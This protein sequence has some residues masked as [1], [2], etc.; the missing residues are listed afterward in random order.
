[1]ARFLATVLRTTKGPLAALLGGVALFA[2]SDGPSAVDSPVDPP[3]TSTGSFELELPETVYA[4]EAFTLTVTAVGADGSRPDAKFG[5]AVALSASSGSLTPS[6]VTL[7]GG[8]GVAAVTLTGVAG[9]VSLEARVGNAIGTRALTAIGNAPVASIEV[10]PSTLLLTG[11]GQTRALSVRVLDADGLPT[12]ADVSWSTSNAGAVSVDADGVATAVAA[13]GSAQIVAQ[14]DGVSSLPALALVATPAPGAVLVDDSLVVGDVTAVDPTAEYGL[15]WRYQV[16]LRGLN[17]QP[18]AV[19]VGTGEQRIGGRVVSATPAGDEVVVVLEL[20]PLPEL[21]AAVQIDQTIPLIEGPDEAA[22][23]PPGASTWPDAGPLGPQRVEF[24]LGRFKCDASG[25]VPD[26]DLPN[27]T[28]NITPSLSL[29][30]GYTIPGGGLQSLAAVGSIGADAGYKPVFKAA[31]EGAVTCSTKLRTL[32]LPIGGW[33]SWFFGAQVP[34]GIGVKLDGK[35]EIAEIGFDVKADATATVELGLDCPPGGSCAGLN[36]F[37]VTRTGSFE[38]VAPDPTDQFKLTL[39]GHGYLWANLTLGSP[40]SESLQFEALAAKAGLKQ[41]VDLATAHKQA[42]DTDYASGFRLAFLANVGPGKDVDKAIKKLGDLLGT[43][44]KPDLTLL[45]VDEDLAESPKGTFTITPASVAPGDDEA[46]GELATFKVELD[47]V[48]YLGLES[49]DRVEIFWKRDDDDGGFTLE[50]GRPGCT[51]ISASAGQTLFECQTDFLAEHE[52]EQTFHAFVHAKL[53]GVPLPIPLEVAKDGS[54]V[55]QVG[56]LECGAAPAWAVPSVWNESW[57]SDLGD[58]G[59][60]K[61]DVIRLD[62]NDISVVASTQAPEGLGWSPHVNPKL[63]TEDYI[64]VLPTD[65]WPEDGII[66]VRVRQVG[67]TEALLTKGDSEIRIGSDYVEL[68]ASLPFRDCQPLIPCTYLTVA[69]NANGLADAGQLV[70]DEHDEVLVW[71][72]ARS[73]DPEK[74]WYRINSYVDGSLRTRGYRRTATGKVEYRVEVLGAEDS[75][76]SPVEVTIC[77]ASGT[78]Y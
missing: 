26:L 58:L 11:S 71:R 21:M 63:G 1:M 77:S 70:V 50:P 60:G 73:D 59:T 51:D 46:L 38:F 4:G 33:F 34:L 36:T 18:G 19:L 54:A 8:V 41:S 75:S 24:T 72:Y 74:A 35:L 5:G 57:I 65:G 3:V 55:L 31:F 62:Y 47:P 52:G 12:R 53:F 27:P 42:E 2:C 76:G 14:A 37:E 49:V 43:E 15:G 9:P 56:D 25:S 78:Q 48:T 40:L 29:R 64:R 32:I 45:N 17:V 7:T 23:G 69:V 20:I 22:G 30:V 10:T 13:L 61:V 28:F 66:N 6:S 16:R 68:R 39:G 44:L 67:R